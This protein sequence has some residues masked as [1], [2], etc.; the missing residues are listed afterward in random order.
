VH[1]AQQREAG[2]AWVVPVPQRSGRAQGGAPAT[3]GTDECQALHPVGVRQGKG[4]QRHPAHAVT[5]R[6][7][8]TLDASGS[9]GLSGALKHLGHAE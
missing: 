3:P 9:Q 2:E 6:V 8:A 5:D 4:Q 1:A 7:E